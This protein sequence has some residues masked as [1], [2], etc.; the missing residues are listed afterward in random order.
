MTSNQ[1]GIEFK[2]FVIRVFKSLGRRIDEISENLTKS[3]KTLKRKSK[4]LKNSSELN[5][6]I[7]EIKNTLEG[8]NKR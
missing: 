1:P 5:D 6:K 8:I 2:T 3:K 4:T 7:T